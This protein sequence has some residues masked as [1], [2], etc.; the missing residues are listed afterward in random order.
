MVTVAQQGTSPSRAEQQCH[1]FL[2]RT[3]EGATV[4]K[5]TLVPATTTTAEYC[6]VRGEMPKDLDFEVRMP[7]Q[8]NGRT[9]FAGGGGFDG[10]ITQ[11]P[12]NLSDPAGGGGYATIAT[13]HGH[14]ANVTPGASFALDVEML[15]EYGY[16]GVPRVLASA[17]TIL[18]ARYG[19]AFLNTKMVYEGCS[20]GGRQGLIQ[21]Q[22][23]PDLFDGV[24]SRAPA[25]AFTPQFLWYQNVAREMAQPG[26]ALT[27]GKI[28][29]IGKA[30]E[31]KCDALDG[32]KDGIIGR[33][34]ACKFDP[35]EL[36]CSAAESD[37]CLT[38]PQV[39]SARAFY[40]PTNVAN[41]R[42]VWPGFSPGGESPTAWLHS[43]GRYVNPLQDGFIR[44]MVAQDP[45]VDALTVE[46]AKYAARLDYLV[47]AI[48]AVDPDLSRFKARGGKLIL[49]TGLSDWLITANNATA[50]YKSVVQRSGGQAAA[51]E[52]IEYYTSPSVQHCAGGTGP[53]KVDLVSPMFEW[54]EKGVKPSSSTIVATRRVVPPGGQQ[55]S[56]PLCRYPQYPRHIGGD[57]NVAANFACT[58]P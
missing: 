4:T 8:W 42:Y 22:R 51:D 2:G 12:L 54:L 50:Y 9:I 55:T 14:N 36:A 48:D 26:A 56:R 18:R 44:Y 49:W 43:T 33:P 58:T 32:L 35:A 6:V 37:S 21:A 7:T 27:A 31:A 19:D 53:D 25:N 5:A 57:P 40:A 15:D 29:A 46:P 20:G 13:N 3:F 52:F 1:A 45:K 23:F 24:I 16:L 39:Q 17:K 38:P 34:D 10:V 41:A 47:S 28:Q 30:V 11:A